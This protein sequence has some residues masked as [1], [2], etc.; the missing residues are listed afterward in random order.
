[1]Q[2][3]TLTQ[4][5]RN[6]VKSPIG[7]LV[8]DSETR[9]E[10]LKEYFQRNNLT[11]CV[12]DRTTEKISELGFSPNLEIIDMFE[13][14]SSRSPPRT[15]LLD[16]VFNAINEAGTISSDALQK[17]DLCL[18]FLL[19]NRKSTIRLVVQGEEDLLALPV[20]AFFPEDTVVFYGQPGEGMV[21]VNSKESRRKA[22]EILER[23]GIGSLKNV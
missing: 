10:S 2:K 23:L 17:L 16:Q 20:V 8:R 6:A 18:D 4:E 9:K 14:R 22:K 7:E 12:G 3:F 5:L 15:G 19:R 21:I 1:M 13:R 11:V